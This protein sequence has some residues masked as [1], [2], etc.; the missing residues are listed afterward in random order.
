MPLPILAAATWLARVR[1]ADP[2]PKFCPVAIV[3]AGVLLVL[4]QTP[5]FAQPTQ[6]GQEQQIGTDTSGLPAAE[7]ERLRGILRRKPP[8]DA[9]FT[10]LRDFYY[11]QF[12]AARRLGDA[13]RLIGLAREWLDAVKGKPEHE[14]IPLWQ[15]WIYTSEYGDRAESAQLGEQV[16]AHPHND[17]LNKARAGC[18]F[19]GQLY[20]NG[21]RGRAEKVLEEAESR[22]RNVSPQLVASPT[23]LR[24]RASCLSARA[25]LLAGQGQY[26]KA[27]D[28]V[29]EGRPLAEQ[30]LAQIV[31]GTKVHDAALT[32]RDGVYG[33]I[34]GVL[35]SAGRYAEAESYYYDF[36]ETW[37]KE[38]SGGTTLA[39]RL[40][41]L[42][43]IQHAAGRSHAA[44]PVFRRALDLFRGAGVG[45]QAAQFIWTEGEII[46]ALIAQE[47]FA[48]AVR[49]IDAQRARLASNAA[50]LRLS[51]SSI[52]RGVAFLMVGRSADALR[53]YEEQ[54]SGFLKRWGPNHFFSAQVRGLYA[55]GLAKTG[56][57]EESL[58]I[59][60]QVLPQL[61]APEGA[62]EGFSDHGIRRAYRRI[63]VEGYLEALARTPR[64]SAALGSGFAVADYLLNSSVQ[65]AVL[66]SA[67]RASIVIPGLGELVRKEQDVRNEARALTVFIE[68][69]AREP[70][71]RRLPKVA[72]DMRKR[73]LELDAARR[74]LR[75]EVA[76]RYPEYFE[77]VSPKLVPLAMVQ[78]ALSGDEALLLALPGHE[79]TF[80]WAVTRDA[81]S[82]HVAELGATAIGQLVASIRRSTEIAAPGALAPPA[83]DVVSARRLF[84]LLLE[85]L[86]PVWQ[87]KS[88][89][90]V[91]L[92]GD[93]GLLP[94][95]LLIA[96]GE[97]EQSGPAYA[98][99]RWLIR[100]A[101]VSHAPSVSAF[102]ALRGA[103]RRGEA[104]VAFV[105]FGDPDFGGAGT[106]RG[107]VRSLLRQSLPVRQ[108]GEAARPLRELYARLPPLPETRDEIL[109]LAAALKA[110]P[111]RSAFLG[112]EAT[113]RRVASLA[114]ADFRVIAFSTHGLAPDEFPGVSEPALALA[115]PGGDKES[116][117]LT[118]TDVLALKLAA[119]WVILSACNTGAA[120]GRAKEALSGL[121]RGFFFAGAKAILLTHWA[122]E[123]HSAKNL[124]TDTVRRFA[125]G[126]AQT[127]AEALR[128]AQLGLLSRVG[129]GGVRY[130]H[131]FYWAPYVVVGEGAR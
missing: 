131:P 62:A 77:L 27:I 120:D 109:E 14:L 73:L 36:L 74:T 39:G 112:P 95:G 91:V 100:D 44:E 123:T 81:A 30:A 26:Q 98:D 67:A 85:P 113:R 28:A 97:G 2:L 129:V 76:R 59:F 31:P 6:E 125:T 99:T 54:A 53:L 104:S 93:L 46:Y 94:F 49:M 111:A 106:S 87:R 96:D 70:P 60:E 10:T 89:L 45:D 58:A 101:A 18:I 122:V 66:E 29:L 72:D 61:T 80:I 5:G 41:R 63:I 90:I 64:G 75:E 88:H 65:E 22:L 56:R 107:A 118:L 82:M 13:Q 86:R 1:R 126:V 48:E 47:R 19:V 20:D 121:A 105:G 102:L 4:A 37:T 16:V 128:Q 119:D 127:R 3:A 83:F 71:H 51:V 108:P 34:V 103:K 25:Y 12:I 21:E 43:Q 92:G 69:E 79:K 38:G 24:A 114:L 110:D 42:G 15:L 115:W 11:E 57:T 78:A 17:P 130:D 55:A 68:R 117:L 32:D 84:R 50:A 23:G 124:V 7:A 116:P 35:N 9:L 33:R 52:A 8:A 40:R